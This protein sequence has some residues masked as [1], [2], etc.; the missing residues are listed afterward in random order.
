[1]SAATNTSLNAAAKRVFDVD[2]TEQTGMKQTKQ[3]MPKIGE[4]FQGGKFA[5]VLTDRAGELYA[6]ILLGDKQEDMDWKAAL[7][8]AQGLQADLPNRIEAAMLF[9]HLDDEFAKERHWTNEESSESYAWICDFNLGNQNNGRKGSEFSARAV[10]RFPLQ[11]FDPF[12][13][14]VSHTAEQ[15]A[16]AR[17]SAQALIDAC[18]SLEL[19]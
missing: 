5:G 7:K 17:A 11:S 19:A 1:M 6:L 14:A 3:A 12:G 4:A 15:V 8:W 10:R 16:K 13:S 9:Q 2:H 18:D